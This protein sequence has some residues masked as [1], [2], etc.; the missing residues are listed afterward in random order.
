MVVVCAV[1]AVGV[2]FILAHA[3]LHDR[4]WTDFAVFATRHAAHVPPQPSQLLQWQQSPVC[5]SVFACV[6]VCVPVN[7]RLFVC[8]LFCPAPFN[9]FH[10]TCAVQAKHSHW[11]AFARGVCFFVMLIGARAS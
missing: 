10:P 6:R 8:V 1:V 7:V 3:G 11:S 4:L 5:A 2:N 9:F